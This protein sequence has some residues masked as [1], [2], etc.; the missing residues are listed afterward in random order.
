M[1]FAAK[2]EVLATGEVSLVFFD[3]SEAWEKVY[4]SRS[5]AAKEAER[6]GV[7]DSTTRRLFEHVTNSGEYG[8]IDRQVDVRVNRLLSTG[9]TKRK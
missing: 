4:P 2:I 8:Y 3:K 9:F 1:S 6:L 7:F 5:V